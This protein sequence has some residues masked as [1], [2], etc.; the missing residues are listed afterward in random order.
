MRIAYCTN[1]RLPSER[2]HGHQIAQ[3]C[4]ALM[5]LGH[6]VDVFAPFRRSS[7][8]EEFSAYYKV[9]SAIRLQ[10]IGKIDFIESIFA[11]GVFGLWLMNSMLRRELVPELHKGSYDIL[12]TRSPALLPALLGIGKPV[13]LELHQLPRLRRKEFVQSCNTCRLV[14]CLTTSMRDTL[15][16]WGVRADRLLVEGDAVDLDRFENLPQRE[17]AE[18]K[19]YVKTDRIIVGYVGRLKTLG[20]EKGVS[21]LLEALADLQKTKQF[22]GLIIGGPEEDRKEYEELARQLGLTEDDVRFAGEIPSASVPVSL[23]ACDILTM[24]FPDLPHYR[25]NMSP[26]KMFE[27]MAAGRPIITSDLPTIRDV[28]SEETAVFCAPGSSESLKQAIVWVHEHPEEA[29]LKAEKARELVKRHTWQER[30]KR[31][32]DHL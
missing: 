18:R 27:Y 21:V 11:P 4:D 3:V 12:Y 23:V 19:L 30:M 22:F 6:A 17:K 9:S 2:A 25:H 7:V 14:I 32:L 1:V 24:P 8:K 10:H 31:I 29:R 13:L 16:S 15:L 26:L 28:L 5:K 20:M